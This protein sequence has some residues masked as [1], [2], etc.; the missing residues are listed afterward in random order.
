A[1]MHIDPPPLISHQPLTPPI[2]DRIVRKCLAKNPE[3][4]WQT[5]GDVLTQLNWIAEAGTQIPVPSQAESGRKRTRLLQIWTVAA[6]T[7]AVA[8]G[9]A[10]GLAYFRPVKQPDEIRFNVSVPLMPSPFHLSISPDGRW[11]AFVASTTPN[12][13]TLFLRPMG[14]TTAQQMAALDG[15]NTTL[16]WSPDT[17]HL[18]FFSGTRLKKI[19]VAGGPAQN[20]C[21]VP[22]GTLQATWNA[23]GIIIFG[24][25]SGLYRVSA[26]G[27]EAVK[28][29]SLDAT[30]QE[31]VHLLPYF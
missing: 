26:A 28:I 2:F 24:S 31:V 8:A 30:S 14:S 3:D 20:V 25:T 13:R 29:T 18:G 5:A 10:L 16:F 17:P 19:D 9:I 21:D 4:R 7:L 22:G 6:T 23:D 27:G 1:I 11:I 15:T 12:V